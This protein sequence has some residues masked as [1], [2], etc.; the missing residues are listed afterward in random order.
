MDL[1]E[2]LRSRRSVQSFQPGRRVPR[3]TL[4]ELFRLA[5]LAPSSWNLQPWR[6]LVVEAAARRAEIRKL[7]WDQPKVTECAALV[8]VLGDTD[9]HRNKERVFAR[10]RANGIIDEAT[11]AR[12]MEAVGAIYPTEYQRHEFAVRNSSFAA[13]QLMLAA[14]G[15]GLASCPM[16]GFD[17]AAVTA[18]L[19]VGDGWILSFLIALGYP[20]GEI[21]FPRQQRFGPEEVVRYDTPD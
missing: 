9:P 21:P 11:H 18:L 2:A 1:F 19:G 17:K 7:A 6:F 5:T 10:W 15:L 12:W 8:V 16:I 13:M 4:D 3:A 20:A 14:H